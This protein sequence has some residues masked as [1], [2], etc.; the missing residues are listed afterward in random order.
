MNKKITGISAT[1][2]TAILIAVAFVRL[3][4]TTEYSQIETFVPELTPAPMPMSV[5]LKDN[6][7]QDFSEASTIAGKIM[8]G[9]TYLPE[10]Y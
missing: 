4:T 5:F 9:P 7:V 2:I 3:P 10:N 1:S 6:Q 8:S